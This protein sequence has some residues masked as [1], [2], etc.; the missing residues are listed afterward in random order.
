MVQ[1][2]GTHDLDQVF[3]HLLRKAQEAVRREGFE[4]V[5]CRRGRRR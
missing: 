2:A 5:W 1:G 4:R 3:A